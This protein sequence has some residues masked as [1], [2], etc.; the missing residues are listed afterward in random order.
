MHF[1]LLSP[2]EASNMFLRP[3]SCQSSVTVLVSWH[4]VLLDGGPGE[5]ESTLRLALGPAGLP[6]FWLNVR[7]R[8]P[9]A[10]EVPLAAPKK[11]PLDEADGP[12]AAIIAPAWLGLTPNRKAGVGTDCEVMRQPQQ[13]KE[14]RHGPRL[15]NASR[16]EQS[17]SLASRDWTA[18][19]PSIGDLFISFILT[20]W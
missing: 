16:T 9:L 13:R 12:A 18:F 14:C 1:D 3:F 11:K 20:S 5:V 10:A 4:S 8:L 17:K 2:L 19:Q 6:R 15:R 7:E